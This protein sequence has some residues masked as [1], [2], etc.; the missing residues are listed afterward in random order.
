[1]QKVLYVVSSLK[2][3]GPINILEGIIKELDKARF[4]VVIACLQGEDFK[5]DDDR[6]KVLG[7]KIYHLDCSMVELE[8]STITATRLIRQILDY[9]KI[10]I[11]HSHGYHADLVVS[12]LSRKRF[13]KVSTQH[14]ISH[15]DFSYSKGFLIGRY[16]SYRLKSAL[17]SFASVVGISEHV[18]K[19]NRSRLNKRVAIE[20]IY[21]GID[22]DVFDISLGDNYKVDR[23]EL[24]LDQNA[25]IFLSVGN[26]RPLKDPITIIQAFGELIDEERLP[27]EAQLIVLGR[28]ELLEDCKRLAKAYH[29]QIFVRGFTKDVPAY[30]H[31][32]D[33]L[34][35]ASHSEGFGLNVAEA[36]ASGLT[37]LVSDLAV[38]KEVLQLAGIEAEEEVNYTYPLGNKEALKEGIVRM[39]QMNP[40]NAIDKEALGNK[41]MSLAYQELYARFE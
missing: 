4:Q 11:V 13:Y 2:R 39:L 27:D 21:N 38:H 25:F 23:V 1:M 9:E 36:L 32:G 33:C 30:L 40:P 37:V 12:L 31:A 15:E 24:G 28:G 41:R 29:R 34:I 18:A 16:M 35:S 20:T 19:Y 10:K 5:G 26:L 6:F 14:N 17:N 8:L 3:V 7:A 22:T